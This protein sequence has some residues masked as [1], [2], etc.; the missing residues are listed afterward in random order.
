M[1]WDRNPWAT[2][3]RVLLSSWSAMVSSWQRHDHHHHHHHHHQR[4]VGSIKNECKHNHR[5][6]GWKI[7]QIVIVYLNEFQFF[8]WNVPSLIFFRHESLFDSWAPMAGSNGRRWWW[9]W[10]YCWRCLRSS[11][12][13]R[14]SVRSDLDKHNH[15]AWHAII[16]VKINGQPST[17]TDPELAESFGWHQLHPS[18][19]WWAVREVLLPLCKKINKTIG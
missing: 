13:T 17:K 4:V 6:F 10:F 14:T 16:I 9:C 2:A 8:G 11:C 12:C 1:I 15:H 3:Y 18:W 7:P 19:I 5:L